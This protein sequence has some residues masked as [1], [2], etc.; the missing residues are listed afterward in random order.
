MS[1]VNV[2][3]AQ[4]GY[5]ARV[6]GESHRGGHIERRERQHRVIPGRRLRPV[7]AVAGDP[8]VGESGSRWFH[9]AHLVDR[10]HINSAMRWGADIDKTPANTP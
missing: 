6:N 1:S 9:A 7:C 8:R 3:A 5:R 4:A 10:F 2:W